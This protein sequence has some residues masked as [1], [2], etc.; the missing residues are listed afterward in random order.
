MLGFSTMRP[1][2]AMRPLRVICECGIERVVDVAVPHLD[3]TI[4]AYARALKCSRCGRKGGKTFIGTIRQPPHHPSN[5]NVIPLFGP[6]DFVKPRKEKTPMW[7]RGVLEAAKQRR[8]EYEK[9]HGKPFQLSE[10]DRR[11][12]KLIRGL[13]GWHNDE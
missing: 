11:T 6:G 13:I 9:E 2:A 3:M 5:G 7:V 4:V 8:E 1:L 10:E 12:A